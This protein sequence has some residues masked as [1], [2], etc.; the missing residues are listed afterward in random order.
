VE[1]S[2]SDVKEMI[3]QRLGLEGP[4][5]KEWADEVQG[6]LERDAGWGWQGF[7]MTVKKNVMVSTSFTFSSQYV[8]PGKWVI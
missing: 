6:L 2:I 8:S 1:E 3:Q 7:W 5:E 4:W